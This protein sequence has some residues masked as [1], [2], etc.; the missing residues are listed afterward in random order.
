MVYY[1]ESTWMG[2][3]H[4]NISV[5]IQ[6]V[7]TWACRMLWER[8]WVMMSESR[9]ML[10]WLGDFSRLLEKQWISFSHSSSVQVLMCLKVNFVMMTVGFVARSQ[11]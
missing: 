9:W 1:V 11:Y 10:L 4:A 3:K 5:M 6:V 2:V 8:G 7:L